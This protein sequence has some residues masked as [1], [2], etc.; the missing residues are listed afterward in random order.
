G[1]FL[2]TIFPL[3]IIYITLCIIVILS[4]FTNQY[5]MA[6]DDERIKIGKR[7]YEKYCSVCHGETGTGDGPGAAI[8]GISPH[9]LTD[10]A[11]MSLL[12][13]DEIIK[14]IRYGEEVFPYLQMSGQ[15]NEIPESTGWDI[16]YYL[17]TIAVD[18]GPLKAPSP[19]EWGNRFKEP[20]ERG[21]TYYLRYCSPCHG[22]S[23][24]GKGWAARG[25]LE[26]KPAALND[27]ALMSKFTEQDILAHVKGLTKKE[28]RKMPIFGRAFTN[29]MISVIAS[30]VKILSATSGK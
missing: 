6:Q 3:K 29:D 17:R 18:K 28:G 13:D 26:G 2:Y 15:S 5:A 30:Y 14:I 20:L 23:G 11:Y 16:V 7:A 19:Q 9:D 24:D 12:S 4:T 25:L 8:S 21:K 1:K 10:K 27:P 22:I